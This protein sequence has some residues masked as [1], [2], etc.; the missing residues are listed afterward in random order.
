MRK[1]A[2]ALVCRRW[3]DM[4]YGTPSLWTTIVYS[5]HQYHSN[6]S[7]T[8]QASMLTDLMDHIHYSSDLP[9]SVTITCWVERPP[10]PFPTPEG[11]G[12]TDPTVP[13]EHAQFRNTCIRWE[14][15]KISYN[16]IWALFCEELLPTSY[17]NLKH[18]TITDSREP[19]SGEISVMSDATSM[20]QLARL[21]LRGTATMEKT[22][23][24]SVQMANV[25]HLSIT[26]PA[27]LPCII[28]LLRQ[29]PLLVSLKI[30]ENRFLVRDGL[31]QSH[32]DFFDDMGRGI[33]TMSL[34]ADLPGLTTIKVCA[35]PS[36]IGHLLRL[37]KCPSLSEMTLQLPSSI[38][39]NPPQHPEP[40]STTSPIPDY[41]QATLDFFQ[42]NLLSFLHLSSCPLTLR[43][44][45]L[46][47]LPINTLLS[48]FASLPR[49]EDLTL[50]LP[51]GADSKDIRDCI[52][53]LQRLIIIP[54]SVASE[55]DAYV[56]PMK[57]SDNLLPN[58]THFR[59]GFVNPSALFGGPRVNRK[60]FDAILPTLVLVLVSRLNI[61]SPAMEE[62][63]AESEAIK[64]L[65]TI[66]V[67]V[68]HRQTSVFVDA[69]QRLEIIA[70]EIWRLRDLNVT[71]ARS[72]EPFSECFF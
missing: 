70:K 57:T 43:K 47:N 32:I 37:L 31:H 26:A 45:A 21:E 67:E 1:V 39:L 50:L 55:A 36:T 65:K 41:D 59:L 9:L 10:N 4:V 18:L 13:N 64:T 12:P 2:L 54:G 11:L 72:K 63:Q 48:M 58:L 25:S 29:M 51:G 52:T 28:D 34:V 24:Q 49:I 68:S 16:H 22:I 60:A 17:P 62:P 38:R 15:L 3:Y 14:S 35:A 23:L 69:F 7:T 71:L 5:A 20:P 30:S 42:R 53:L 27:E 44:L 46:S 66:R 33:D 8:H 19:P 40:T 61:T 6:P 56:P